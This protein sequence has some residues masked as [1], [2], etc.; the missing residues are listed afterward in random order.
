MSNLK[1]T[2]VE[3]KLTGANLKGMI[4]LALTGYETSV[5]KSNAFK[6]VINHHS[7]RL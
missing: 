4:F 3:A 6:A 5:N 1:L 2:N 7:L